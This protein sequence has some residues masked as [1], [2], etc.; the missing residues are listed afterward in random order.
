MKPFICHC[1][2]TRVKW[3]I[4]FS[5]L[6]VGLSGNFR[7]VQGPCE[8]VEEK[9]NVVREGTAVNL[10]E[11]GGNSSTGHESPQFPRSL[12][13]YEDTIVKRSSFIAQCF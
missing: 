8:E 4:T 10:Q 11:K 13:M 9:I 2:A 1:N 5:S 7:C 6:L 3:E 12:P